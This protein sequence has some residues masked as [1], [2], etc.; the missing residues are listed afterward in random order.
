MNKLH[1]H[2]TGAGGSPRSRFIRLN[3]RIASVPQL[4][5][6]FVGSNQ[7]Q[8]WYE[9]PGYRPSGREPEF[10]GAERAQILDDGSNL[11]RACSPLAYA[12]SAPPNLYLE[13]PFC[14]LDPA[15]E[16]ASARFSSA[17]LW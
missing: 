13:F 4:S 9:E 8:N 1:H 11:S 15:I 5:D 2:L 16:R 14:L 17:S 3:R 12:A 6:R 7:I 10:A